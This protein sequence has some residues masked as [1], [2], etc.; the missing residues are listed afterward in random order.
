M[1]KIVLLLLLNPLFVFSQKSINVK[2]RSENIG[3]GNNNCLVVTIYEAKQ[4][5]I[6]KAWKSE[7]KKL[8]G[9]VSDKKEIFADDAKMKSMGDNTFD[10]YSKVVKVKDDEHELWVGV[11]L[12]G[13]FLSSSQHSSQYKAMKDF[14]YVFALNTSKE[15]MAGQQIRERKRRPDKR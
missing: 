13:A 3:G 5:E 8:D 11:D 2:E 6:E 12:G 10:L 1:K 9:K 4:S 7:L 14:V 15:A